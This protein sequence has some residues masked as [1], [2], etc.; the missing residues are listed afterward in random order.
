MRG[1]GGRNIKYP[2][3]VNS[4]HLPLWPPG[5]FADQRDPTAR[6]ARVRLAV[7]G[8]VPRFEFGRAPRLS[9]ASRLRQSMQDAPVRRRIGQRRVRVGMR[10]L[11]LVRRLPAKACGALPHREDT[12][13][14]AREIGRTGRESH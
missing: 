3:P 10:V 13:A 6:L 8:A 14:A 5:G 1:V 4:P 7:G 9:S 12:M 2:P 11:T